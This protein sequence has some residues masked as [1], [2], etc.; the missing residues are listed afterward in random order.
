VHAQESGGT[1]ATR[2]EMARFFLFFSH[3]LTKIYIY[4]PG[5]LIFYFGPDTR[6]HSLRQ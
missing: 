3:F 5:K 1:R 6:R 4:T 2:F